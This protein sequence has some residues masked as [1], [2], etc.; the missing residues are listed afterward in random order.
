M[1]VWLIRG[2]E[3]EVLVH[4]GSGTPDLVEERFG[5]ELLQT[6]AQR[7]EAALRAAGVEPGVLYAGAPYPSHSALYERAVVQRPGPATGAAEAARR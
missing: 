4:S 3:R 1:L 7:P 5:R 2:G 6:P